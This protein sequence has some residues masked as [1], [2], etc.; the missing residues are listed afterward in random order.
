MHCLHLWM[1]LL[2]AS[3]CC[4]A[5]C[6]TTPNGNVSVD[7]TGSYPSLH[8]KKVEYAGARTG[9]VRR[10]I[11]AP[12]EV[13]DA[14]I[15]GA[16]DFGEREARDLRKVLRDISAEYG[17]GGDPAKEL[18]LSLRIITHLSRIGEIWPSA[19][20]LVEAEYFLQGPGLDSGVKREVN[21]YYNA[22]F[23]WTIESARS[24]MTRCLGRRI[25]TDIAC[26]LKGGECV[27]PKKIGRAIFFQNRGDVR[28]EFLDN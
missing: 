2:I 10:L 23:Y 14:H 27:S 16:G 12:E 26:A 25:I 17:F 15:L 7:E 9:L 18:T 22:R 24:D 13:M 6:S 8:V 5:T 3:V 28:E 11:G 21:M 4:A 20:Y 1:V 19:E